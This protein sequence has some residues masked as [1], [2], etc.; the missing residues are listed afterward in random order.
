VVFGKRKR[1]GF[2]GGGGSKRGET[3]SSN[4]KIK[5]VTRRRG[6][7][8]FTE[9]AGGENLVLDRYI[10]VY[11]C[12]EHCSKKYS[13]IRRRKRKKG[14]KIKYLYLMNFW[15]SLRKKVVCC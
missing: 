10:L 11:R 6:N 7:I 2:K 14:K 5:A 12:K 13:S 3:K 15:T 9:R 1:K 8:F 4:G